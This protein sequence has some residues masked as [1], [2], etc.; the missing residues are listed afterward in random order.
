MVAR[1]QE[2]RRQRHRLPR[3]HEGVGVVGDE[4]E[5]HAGEEEVVPEALQAGRGAFA[6]ADVAGGEHRYA[7]RHRAEQQQEERRQRVHPEVERQVGEAERGDVDVRRRGD[8]AERDDGERGTERGAQREQDVRDEAQ[9]ARR[10]EA[11]RPDREPRHRDRERQA[12]RRGTHSRADEAVASS[13]ATRVAI[14]TATSAAMVTPTHRSKCPPAGARRGDRLGRGL[15]GALRRRPAAARSRPRARRGRG[16]PSARRRRRRWRR[17]GAASP[18]SSRT[19][20]R[21]AGVAPP[22]GGSRCGG[23]LRGGGE[24][25]RLLVVV[26][27]EGEGADRQGLGGVVVLARGGAAAASCDAAGPQ[28]GGEL[29]RVLVARVGVL[30]ERAREDEVEHR[31][32]AAA[33]IA[34]GAGGAAFTIWYMICVMSSPEKGATPT[35]AS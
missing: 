2:E 25:D 6:R 9:A 32:A 18:R 5:R 33:W 20:A 15:G 31:P 28:V 11:E 27:R 10:D 3:D 35:A 24:R 13:S 1:H 21:C 8:R 14:A 4:H 23:A 30:R 12:E 7:R 22:R 17:R 19:G 34:L 16:G 29:A 26:A